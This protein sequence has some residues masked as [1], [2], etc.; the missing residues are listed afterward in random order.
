MKLIKSESNS[1]LKKD[2]YSKKVYL[3]DEDLG[4]KGSLVQKLKIEPGETV[5]SHSHKIQTEI[6]YF[7]NKNGYFIINGEKI[8][9]EVDDVL[10]VEPFDKHIVVNDTKKDFLY[11]TFKLNY[12][13]D[14]FFWD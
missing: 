11:M 7:L 3:T 10:V 1:W 4:V 9:V 13:E 8:N 6:F 12:S 2:G 5:K 14:D